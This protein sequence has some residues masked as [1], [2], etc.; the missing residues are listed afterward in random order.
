MQRSEFAE[1]ARRPPCAA[2]G[3]RTI[4]YIRERKKNRVR[5]RKGTHTGEFTESATPTL[6]GLW[7]EDDQICLWRQNPPRSKKRKGG[8]RENEFTGSATP[9][10]RGLWAGGNK[11]SKQRPLPRGREKSICKCIQR[12]R[13]TPTPYSHWAA[14]YQNSTK[15]D[16]G[17]RGKVIIYVT[18][19]VSPRR[20]CV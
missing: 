16:G 17:R 9:T 10:L 4:Q 8:A 18:G 2:T 19:E 15:R 11:K 6:Y 20:A 14:D 12:E 13:T 3:P 5:V 7:A 1:R